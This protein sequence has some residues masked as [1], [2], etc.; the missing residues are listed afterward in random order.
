MKALSGRLALGIQARLVILV[1]VTVLPLVGVASF[2]MIR[3]VDDERARIERDVRDRV[4]SLLADVDRQIS[5]IQAELRVLAVSPSLQTDDFAAF[6]RQMREA[7]K[8]QGTSIVLHDTEAQQLLSTNRPF[9]EPLPRATNREMHDR[10]VET[11]KPQI[12]DL[13]IGAVLRRPILTIGVPVFV[14]AR[15]CTS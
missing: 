7:L 5:S 3:T 15:S 2:V 12:S 8:I 10:V 6:D 9:G 4:E 13:I 11:G 1:L 14:A